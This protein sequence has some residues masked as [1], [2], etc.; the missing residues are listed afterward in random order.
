M[1]KRSSYMQYHWWMYLLWAMAVFAIWFYLF[2][3]VSLPK[4]DEKL[5]IA[6]FD[7]DFPAATLQWYISHEIE[8]ITEQEIVS[9]KVE[10]CGE[11]GDSIHKM[12]LS[13]LITADLIIVPE[14]M[15]T[16]DKTQTDKIRVENF[17]I[18][19]TD[20]LDAMVSGLEYYTVGDMAYG[21]YLTL[22]D[23]ITNNFESYLE[24]GE[25]YILFFCDESSN[26]GGLFG[27]GDI[28]DRAGIDALE[29]LLEETNG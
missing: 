26:H 24:D 17:R 1:K 10:S 2:Y 14:T 12:V 18:I 7:K 19:P 20:K 11:L 28:E 29:Y 3:L 27:I 15:L 4:K 5:S 13:R 23:G 16:T 21:V 22:D 25:R 9:V 6:V 8:D